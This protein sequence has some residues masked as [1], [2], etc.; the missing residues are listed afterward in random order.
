MASKNNPRNRGKQV[1]VV[2]CPECDAE[3]IR[4]KRVPGGM[5]HICKDNPEHIFNCYKHS[6]VDF[7]FTWTTR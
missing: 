4:V 2:F 6:Y 5:F 1:L 7:R 3:M